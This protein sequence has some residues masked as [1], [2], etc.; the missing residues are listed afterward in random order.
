MQTSENTFEVVVLIG[1]PASGKTTFYKERFFPSHMYISLDQ[2]KTRSAEK[3]LFKFCLERSKNCVID[4]TNVLRSGRA[5][6]ISEAKTHGAKVIGYCFV[7]AKEDALKRN[8][9]RSG[10]ARIKDAAVAAY[11]AK[12]EYPVKEEGFDELYFVRLG[13][14]GFSVENFK[15]EK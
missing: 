8:A 12:L 1:I 7:T 4:N 6:Y 9:G 2:V 11:Y 13:D 15:D 10:R 5:V 3:E 14:G